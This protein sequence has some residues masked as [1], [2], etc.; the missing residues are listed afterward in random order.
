MLAAK[1]IYPLMVDPKTAPKIRSSIGHAQE[2][3]KA[4]E[5]A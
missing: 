4:K 5:R 3:S 1:L 2:D